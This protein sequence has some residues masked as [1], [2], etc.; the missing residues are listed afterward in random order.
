MG[1]GINISFGKPVWLFAAYKTAGTATEKPH[2]V[3]VQ[4]NTAGKD[5]C[6]FG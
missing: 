6:N 2:F 5:L 4:D 1:D 3:F